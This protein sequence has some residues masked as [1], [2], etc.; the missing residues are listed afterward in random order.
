MLLNSAQAWA[1]DTFAN[2][3]LGDVRRTRRLVKVAA[4]MASKVGASIVKS[5]PTPASMEGAYR[6]IRN[7]N[8]E[9]DQIAEAGFAATA[10]NAKDYG[11]LL[12]LEDTTDLTYKHKSLLNELGHVN[13]KERARSML[14]HSTLLFAPDEQQVVGL[15]EQHRWVRDINTRGKKH[16][17]NA[18]PYEE[19]EAYKWERASRAMTERLGDIQQRVISVCDRESDIYEYLNYKL[20]QGHR[21]VVRSTH[22][23]CIEDGSE[24][25]YNYAEELQSA[26]LRQIHIPQ[27]GGRKARDVTLEIRFAKVAVNAPLDKSGD[28]LPLY[29][30]GCAEGVDSDTRLSWHILTTEP[31]TTADEAQRIFDF[32]EYRWLIEEFHKGWKS[33]GTK[34]EELLVQSRETLERVAVIKAFIA[35]RLLQLRAMSRQP[36]K[37]SCESAL[38]QEQWKLLWLK[39][40]QK[41]LPA[42]PPDLRWACIALA[43]LGGW[44]DSKRTGRPGWV[45]LW[46]GW[47]ALAM[48]LEGYHLARSLGGSEM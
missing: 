7:P 33:G 37:Q 4:D 28:K 2:A 34:V 15:I 40:E 24:R 22:N 25:L 36:Q 6:L 13:H 17:R 11:L 23:R 5:C 19:K 47:L 18:I 45:V 1:T 30:V 35:V 42:T 41:P 9:P 21:F 29:Y 26:G 16:K 12:A 44:H 20:T 3:D 8:V 32:Y 38:P 31:V 48:M 39:V 46:D 14:A 27:K 43:K 10:N